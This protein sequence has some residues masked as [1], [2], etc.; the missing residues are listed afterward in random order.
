MAGRGAAAPE[1]LTPIEGVKFLARDFTWRE[2]VEPITKDRPFVGTF[3]PNGEKRTSPDPWD[4]VLPGDGDRVIGVGPGRT[5]ARLLRESC[6]DC[7]VGIIPAAIG[8]TPV[9]AWLPGGTDPADQ[10]YHPYDKAIEFARFAMQ[11]GEI[12]AILWHQGEGDANL[13]TPDYL[14]KLRTVIENFRRDLS[15]SPQVPFIMGTLASFY[16]DVYPTITAGLAKVDSAMAAIAADTDYT[17]VV[18]TKDLS[19][20]GD[21][22]HFSGEAQHTLG[23]RYFRMW[24]SLTAI[25]PERAEQQRAGYAGAMR[26]ASK[27]FLDPGEFL[28]TSPFGKRCHPVTGEEDSFHAGIDGALWNGRMLLETF[29]CAVRDGTVREAADSEGP[30]GTYVVIDHGDRLATKYCHLERGS[31]RVK[32]GDRISAGTV[33][34]YMG[35]TGRATGEHLHFEAQIG[36]ECVDPIPYLTDK[37][38]AP[39]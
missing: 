32:A 13:G 18:S 20:R 7:E 9:S 31:L 3:G 8:G 19:H 25:K 37:G 17:G 10:S 35:K 28:V 36:G 22:L 5:F 38:G 39:A 6:P 11:E 15:L 24:K 4:T 34:G 30:A 12:V 27:V 33:L 1:D 16:G 26:F 29:I 2:A 14:E 21:N 23:E